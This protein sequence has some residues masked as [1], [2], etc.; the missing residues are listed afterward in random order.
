MC[1]VWC[2]CVW[3]EEGGNTSEHGDQLNLL[4]AVTDLILVPTTAINN[5]HASAANWRENS[6][7][8][9]LRHHIVRNVVLATLVGGKR[10]HEMHAEG[11]ELVDGR[12][13]VGGV[14]DEPGD[15]E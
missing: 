7:N 6:Q 14:H 2:V 10:A 13:R 5:P 11:E 1:G 4:L 3:Y 9:R 15:E 12:E 8:E